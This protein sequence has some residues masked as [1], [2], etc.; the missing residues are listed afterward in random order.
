MS[1][2]R[3]VAEYANKVLGIFGLKIARTEHF[4]RDWRAHFQHI[5]GKDFLPSV[6]F[7]VGVATKT[8]YL[9]DAFPGAKIILVEPLEEYLPALR[10]LSLKYSADIV[11]AAAGATLGSI[12]INVPMDIG[13]QLFTTFQ[14]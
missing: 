14:R 10:D 12:T 7:D 11:T 8:E 13:G 5:S 3:V 4:P 6:L 9:Y 2:N 1:L